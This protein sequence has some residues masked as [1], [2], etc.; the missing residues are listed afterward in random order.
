MADC[1]AT[2]AAEEPRRGEK[3]E[4]ARPKVSGNLPGGMREVAPECTDPLQRDKCSAQHSKGVEL[5][6]IGSCARLLRCPGDCSPPLAYTHPP[7]VTCVQQAEER[8]SRM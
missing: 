1:A 8:R 6:C 4:E 2:K 3:C 7:G 5:L